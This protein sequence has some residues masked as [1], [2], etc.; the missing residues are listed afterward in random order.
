M[1]LAPITE[2][3]SFPGYYVS[4][5]GDVFNERNQPM[6]VSI[7]QQ[8]IAKTTLYIHGEKKTRSI[9]TL[10]AETYLEVEAPFGYP[11]DTP[12]NLDGDRTNNALSNL[13]MRTRTFAIRYHKQ[14]KSRMFLNDRQPIR[15]ISDM[16]DF[17]TVSLCCM[18]Y[19]LVYQDLLQ[20]THDRRPCFPVLKRF[21]FIRY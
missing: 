12:I 10:V 15:C 16:V 13:A 5:E 17:D 7:N 4:V 8:G 6:A 9:A 18:E 11:F 2:I 21:E 20:A 3:P 14:F 1:P 19:G